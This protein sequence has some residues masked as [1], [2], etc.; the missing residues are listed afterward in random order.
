MQTLLA[1]DAE[2]DVR[3]VLPAIRAPTLLV[4]GT[5]D[6]VFPVGGAR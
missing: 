4:H 3:N 5:A 2:I 1:M 6:D